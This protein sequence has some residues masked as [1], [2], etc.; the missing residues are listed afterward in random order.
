MNGSVSKLC[1]ID[2]IVIPEEMLNVSVDEARIEEEIKALSLRYA[3]ERQVDKVQK[4]DIVYCEADKESFPDGR[5]IILYTDIDVPRAENASKA[6]LGMNSGESFETELVGKKVQLTVNKIVR[7]TPAEVTDELVA[8]MGV[9]GV[10]TIDEYRAYITKR[11]EDDQKMENSK[12]LI[13]YYIDQMVNGSTY[14][15][16]ETEMEDYVKSVLEAH[17][18]EF[19]DPMDSGLSEDDIKES[20][21]AQK[22]QSWMTKAFC[23]SQGITIDEEELNEQIAQ[24]REMMELVG[25]AVPDSEELAE[26][27]EDDMYFTN[28]LEYVNNIVENK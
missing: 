10:S 23:E 8:G 27:V 15:Y 6:S 2:S 19:I 21:I 13:G 1:D 7:R 4:G 25:E 22:K 18:D 5:T 9:E 20:V 24:T 17:Q 12:M 14:D 3:E 16:D 28:F 11:A 26:M